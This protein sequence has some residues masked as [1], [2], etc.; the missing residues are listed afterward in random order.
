MQHLICFSF[1][2]GLTKD[3]VI[4]D[5]DAG[6]VRVQTYLPH[7]QL[8]LIHLQLAEAVRAQA[9]TV[10]VGATSGKIEVDLAKESGQRW[11]TLGTPLDRH[12]WCGDRKV[13]TA[14]YCLCALTITLQDVPVTY[15]PWTVSATRHVT[16]N[17]INL[18]LTPPATCHQHVSPGHHVQLRAVIEDTEIVRSYTPVTQL[19]PGSGLAG[20]GLQF[21]VKIYPETGALT[22]H[23]ASLRPGAEVSVSDTLLSGTF[24]ATQLPDSADSLVTLLAAGTGLTPMIPI[25]ASLQSRKQRPRLRLITFDTNVR[26]IIWKDE[27]CIFCSFKMHL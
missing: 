13:N 26:D 11:R 3:N 23:L 10:R 1:R 20:A 19:T 27:V 2:K 22:P 4:V 12:L 5:L 16:H 21:L 25:L 7:H 8:F 15:R 17:T 14:P 9:A 24:S 6:V 18:V